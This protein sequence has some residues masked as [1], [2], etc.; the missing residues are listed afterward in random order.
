MYTYKRWPADELITKFIRP[1]PSQVYGMVPVPKSAEISSRV[2]IHC[3]PDRYS[4][5]GLLDYLPLEVLPRVF[6]FLDFLLLSRLL[7]VS[8]RSKI[9]VESLPAYREVIKYVP[10]VLMALNGVGLLG[11]HAATTLQEALGFDR[12][13]V[14]G[15]CGPLLFLPTCERCGLTC[16]QDNPAF[17]VITKGSAQRYFGLRS[18]QIER[19]PNIHSMPG[20]YTVGTQST[21]D[22]G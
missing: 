13:V 2:T 6:S 8:V 16:L 11:V 15:D 18:E 4:S 3:G 5:A 21:P 17:W 12:C 20:N 19:I 9:F 1:E 10:R 22:E 7:R 14:C